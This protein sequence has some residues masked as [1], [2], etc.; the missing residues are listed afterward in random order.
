M[1]A[2]VITQSGG[3]EVLQYREVA[4]P[5]VGP[6]EVRIRVIKTS[7]NFADIKSRMGKKGAASFPFIPG[8][9]ATG[10][11]DELG[12]EVES[13][14]TGQRVIAFPMNGSY[15]EYIVASPDLVFPIPDNIDFLTA[16]AC[17]IVSFLSHR[18][19]VNVA[20]IE[21]GDVV[22]IHAAAGGVG[23]TATQLAKLLGASLVIGT[24]GSENKRVIA[25]ES[26]ADY[27]ICYEQEDFAQKVNEI[28]EGKGANIILDS[29]SGKVTENSLDCLAPYGRLVHFGN[30]SGDIGTIK[31][32]ELHSTCRSVLGFS[33]GTTRKLKPYLL[34]ETAEQILPFLSSK[35]LKIKVGHEFP[36]SEAAQAHYLMENR[37]NIGKIILNID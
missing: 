14:Y 29:V 16:A 35:Q 19:L 34:K 7:V 8:L 23:S 6:K 36:L 31:T 26:G 33:L 4:M 10:Y 3:P 17:P 30:S 32:T 5:S 25:E 18:L 24:V 21:V 9:D 1:K 20:R 13:L 27:V 15:A 2:V 37:L 11:I 28:T 22:L 12:S